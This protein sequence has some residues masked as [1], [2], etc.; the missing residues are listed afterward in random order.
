MSPCGI[1]SWP[2]SMANLLKH[3]ARRLIRLFFHLSQ[4]RFVIKSSAP[5]FHNAW[6][7]FIF[8]G[9]FAFQRVQ[10]LKPHHGPQV[11][12][13]V[14]QLEPEIHTYIILLRSAYDA[15]ADTRNHNASL[16]MMMASDARIVL[17]DRDEFPKA[18]LCLV[19][20]SLQLP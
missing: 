19:S 13:P 17:V 12:L 1:E 11:P 6:Y 14:T 20:F 2:V 10:P 3:D 7:F 15:A 16:M 9:P 5:H 8:L 4:K 18:T